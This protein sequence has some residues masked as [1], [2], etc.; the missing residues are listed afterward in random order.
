MSLTLLPERVPQAPGG[1]RQQGVE[2]WGGGGASAPE[3]RR[4]AGATQVEERA[5]VQ[6]H[7]LV[8]RPEAVAPTQNRNGISKSHF[9]I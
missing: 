8:Q 5:L 9:A 6:T 7:Q 2:C 1:G 4:E 3:Q